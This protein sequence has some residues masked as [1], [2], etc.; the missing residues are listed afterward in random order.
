MIIY[1]S[2]NGEKNLNLILNPK[3]H[4]EIGEELGLD[5]F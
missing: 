2:K 4:F 5:K 1:F 3:R